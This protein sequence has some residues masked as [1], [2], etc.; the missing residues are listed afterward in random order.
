LEL[1]HALALSAKAL[2]AKRFR[3]TLGV[4]HTAEQLARKHG[5]DPTPVKLAAALHDLGK[6]MPLSHQL[7]LAHRWNLIRCQEDEDSPHILH[8]PVAAYWLEHVA[9]IDNDLI[10]K[11]VA[12]HTLGAPSMSEFEMIVYSADLIEPN[13]NF[14]EVDI[15]RNALY[16]NLKIGTLKCVEHTL[17]YLKK[18]N[19]NIHPLTMETYCDLKRR[20]TL[21]T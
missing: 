18:A 7:K 1:Q 3:H 6:G 2:S 12:H 10:L 17:K 21:G 16:D 20:A 14:P 13:R 19:R 11:A 5:L 4:V 9:G 15:L 8:G